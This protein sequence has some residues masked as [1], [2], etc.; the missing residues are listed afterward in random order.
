MLYDE[1]FIQLAQRY[2][3]SFRYCAYS[4]SG[5]PTVW[6]FSF[7]SIYLGFLSVPCLAV[8]NL[9]RITISLR[10]KVSVKPQYV[11]RLGSF[12]RITGNHTIHPLIERLL[13]TTGI[14]PTPFGNSATKVAGLQCMPLHPAFAVHYFHK[15]SPS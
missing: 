3:S 15:K 2:F 9:V 7:Y 8:A 1:Y 14:E 12:N 5:P 10:C 11:L 4:K 6:V 13:S